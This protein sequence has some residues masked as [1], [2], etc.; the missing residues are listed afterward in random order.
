MAILDAQIRMTLVQLFRGTSQ[1]LTTAIAITYATPVFLIALLPL[2]VAYYFVQRF[3]I[4]TSNQLR[5]IRSVRTSPIYS[6]FGESVSGASS[7]RAYRV[8]REFTRES[9]RLV[10]HFQM[11]R[12]PEMAIN[13]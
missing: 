10:D 7:I 13:R 11:A 5:R 1:L 3:Y 2:G 6:H 4:V 12:F 8:S 9:D